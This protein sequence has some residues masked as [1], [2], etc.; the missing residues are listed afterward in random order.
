M[1]PNAMPCHKEALKLL[2]Y[3][4]Q[5]IEEAATSS[6]QFCRVLVATAMS[7]TAGVQVAVLPDI[8]GELVVQIHT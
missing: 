2:G 8:H 4:D 3:D 7:Q 6:F 1:L 5:E